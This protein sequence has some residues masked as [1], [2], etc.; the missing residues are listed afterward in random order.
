MADWSSFVP[1]RFQQGSF[2][3]SQQSGLIRSTTD[4]GLPKQRR[5]FTALVKEFSVNI[6]MTTLEFSYFEAWFNNTIAY[7]GLPFNFPDP[8]SGYST[9]VIARF[10]SADEIYTATP[11]GDSGDWQVSFTLE[12][13]PA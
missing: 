3:Y 4:T 1:Y 10:K 6:I 8:F 9:N 7:G 13:V 11:N 12:V 2:S 5:R